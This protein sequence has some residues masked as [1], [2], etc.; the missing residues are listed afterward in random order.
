MAKRKKDRVDVVYSTNPDYNYDYKP[1]QELD[2]LEPSDQKLRVFV[3]R[4]HRNGKV[5]TVVQ[6]FIGTE[7]D[8]KSLAKLLKIKCG[9]GGAAK[10]GEI[11]IQG[12]LSSKILEILRAENYGCRKG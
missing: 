7:D 4:K 1:D 6:N 10:E 12:D 5:V 9:V 11:L 3:D 8:L 2:T